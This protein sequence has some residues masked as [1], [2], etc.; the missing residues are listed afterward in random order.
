MEICPKHTEFL[1]KNKYEKYCI[2]L[3]C[4]IRI[5]DTTCLDYIRLT[6]KI[7]VTTCLDYSRPTPPP[8]KKKSLHLFYDS[9]QQ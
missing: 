4:I 6:P 7:G 3:G 5:G 2:S 9:W 1:I 8:P